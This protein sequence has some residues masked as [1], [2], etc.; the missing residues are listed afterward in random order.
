M[1][2]PS[3]PPIAIDASD[4][5][6]FMRTVRMA[7]SKRLPKEMGAANK[8]IGQLVISRLSPP[9]TPAAVGQ[10]R[11][12]GIRPSASRREV[13]LRVGG[14]HREGKAPRMQWGRR[15]GRPVRQ[16]APPRPYIKRTAER[17]RPEIEREWL[18]AIADAFDRAFYDTEP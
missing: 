3:R 9:P 7:E 15:S 8:R 13:V 14:K 11:G 4:W 2:R 5:R 12:A 17:H 6:R 10:G 1:A 18:K 16:Q